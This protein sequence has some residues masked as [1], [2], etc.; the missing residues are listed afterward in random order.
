VNERWSNLDS[1]SYSV[2]MTSDL[3]RTLRNH[4]TRG[5]GQ[6]DLCFVLWRPSTGADRHSAL[7]FDV[8][9]PEAG[10]RHVHGNASFEGRYLLRAAGIASDSRCGL[11]LIHSHPGG[12]GWQRM[13]DDDTAAERSN[14]A[15]V[16][17]ITG[18]PFLGLTLATGDNGISARFWERMGPRNYQPT[19]CDSVRVVG[20][21]LIV[22][23]NDD[24]RPPPAHRPAQ[25]RTVAAWGP[26]AHRELTRLRVGIVGAGSVG[27]MVAESLSRSGLAD[28]VLIDFDSVK[29]H[30][31][32]RLLHA[33]VDD[34]VLM[35]P[36]V[37]VLADALRRSSTAATPRT[38]AFEHS[39]VEPAGFHRALDCDV[40]FS[41]VDRPWARA[42]LNLIAYAHLI[43]VVDGGIA[44]RSHAGHIRGA[45]WRAH[46][47]APGR[48]CLECLQQY[49]PG[50]VQTERNGLLDDP[51]Y[52]LGLPAD[53]PLRR[54][55]NV[56]AFSAACAAA[57]VLQML[58]MV[59]APAGVADVGAQ[60]F[61]FATG[62]IDHE[63]DG[64]EATCIYS[65]GQVALGDTSMLVVTGAHE[66]AER[67]R[68]ARARDSVSRSDHHGAT[69]RVLGTLAELWRSILSLKRR[70]PL[71]RRS[72]GV[73]NTF[74][75]HGQ[76]DG[77]VHEK[78]PND[79]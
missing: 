28:I 67:E 43:P 60:L 79:E 59:L 66:L 11:A 33:T 41:C 16:R 32:D 54:N 42:A 24:L 25:I 55:E 9:V 3:A 22:T 52:I 39:I 18:L 19:W 12:R 37:A 71:S 72:A 74:T 27:A 78:G 2:A 15:Q 56:F 26:D 5:D 17:A 46:V 48:R 20:E 6:E 38:R 1:P 30:N 21:Q 77:S 36:K 34:A 7:A 58:T 13:S 76:A 31:L 62:T 49:D 63:R 47:A 14:A 29:E 8:V 69:H 57:M 50:V 68:A 45:E 35:R 44:V 75:T 53:H 65:P 61:H 4:L 64:C 70:L 23:F 51:G 10:E 40:L 73:A